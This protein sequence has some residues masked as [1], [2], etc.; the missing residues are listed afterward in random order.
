MNKASN[1]VELMRVCQPYPLEGDAFDNFHVE[2]SEARGQNSA[3]RLSDYF[4]VNRNEPQKVLFMGHRGS[5]KTTELWQVRKQLEPT[6]HVISFSIREET[7]IMDL[8]YMDL[9]FIVMKRLFD[10]VKAL[11][12]KLNEAALDNLIDYWNNEKIL[13]KTKT[14]KAEATTTAEAKIGFLT[15]LTLGVKGILSTGRET[16]ELIR[17]HIEPRLSKLIDSIND[18]IFQVNQQLNNHNKV[19]IIIIEDLDK[20]EIPIAED[21]FLNHRN[22]LTSLNMHMIYTFPIFLLYSNKFK[23]IMDSFNHHELLSMIKINLI[24][25]NTFPKGREVLEKVVEAR[26]DI[27]LFEPGVLDF[28]IDKTGGVLRNILE[29]I[30]AATLTER[31]KNRAATSVSLDS[32]KD[33]YLNFKSDFERKLS[34][35]HIIPLKNLALDQSK[36]PLSDHIL[37]ELLYSTAVIEY[38]GERWCDV[39][40]TVKDILRERGII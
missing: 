1:L 6:F 15:Q 33:A 9:I 30:R 4:E 35:P 17:S 23:E 5:G 3:E 40:P 16:K 24:N 21:L 22:V 29:I 34:E 31:G 7:D 28:I 20:L 8:K 12:I 39:H 2:T 10:E 13:E 14:E 36:K 26:A 38:N 32:A 27:T 37:M 19:P 11:K 18:L 25:G